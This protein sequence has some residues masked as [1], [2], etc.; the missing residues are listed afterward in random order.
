MDYADFEGVIARGEYGAGPVIVWDRGVYRNVTENR[1]KPVPIAKA[2][3][4]GHVSIVL[5]GQKLRGG[6]ALTR[7][8]A[9]D[10]DE[11]WLLVK[12][13][14]EYADPDCDIVAD[15]PKSATSGKTIEEVARG[16]RR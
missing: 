6:F 15:E 10:G 16:G 13:D 7:F 8:R 9:G 2:L 12:K 1:G 11:H 3:A 5:A 4:G 14:D